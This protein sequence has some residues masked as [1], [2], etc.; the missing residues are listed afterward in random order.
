MNTF[1]F[2]EPVWLWLLPF[3]LFIL[4]TFSGNTRPVAI[5][6]STV[7]LLNPGEKSPRSGLGKFRLPLRFL[8]LSILILAL[9]QPRMEQG[10]DF[11]EN[12]GIDVV[13]VLDYSASMDEKDFFI[14]GKAISRLDALN[15]VIADF[16]EN[17][18][19]DRIGV[20]GFAKDPYL[21]SPLTTDHDFVTDM[22]GEVKTMGGTAIG[23]GMVAAIEMLKDSETES[24]VLIVVTDGLSNTGVPPL[25]AAKYAKEKDV[26][27]YP[28][29]ILNYRKLSPTRVVDHPLNTIAKMTGGQ[30][31]QAADYTS[32]ANIYQQIDDLE[33]SLIKERIFK[34]YNELF[35]SFLLIG[36]GM[37]LLE[38]LLSIFFRRSLP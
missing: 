11:E 35:S 38:I 4:F 19:R 21:V 18:E 25:E 5:R 3:L 20:I 27:V 37:L 8:T 10:S 16:I 29:E 14:E 32:L 28:I 34:V 31:Y 1:T 12:E 22:M 33:T 9:A 7:T 24:K 30:F 6:F 36:L 15:K 13:L 17:R 23:S 2:G 26:R